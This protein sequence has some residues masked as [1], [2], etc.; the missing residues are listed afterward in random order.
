[1]VTSVSQ[2]PSIAPVVGEESGFLTEAGV[3]GAEL[4]ARSKSELPMASLGLRFLIYKPHG[5]RSLVGHSIAKSQT[6][7]ND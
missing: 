1:M 5:W 6:R 2:V 7:F 3:F 4:E